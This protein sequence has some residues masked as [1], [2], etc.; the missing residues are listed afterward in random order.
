VVLVLAAPSVLSRWWASVSCAALLVLAVLQPLPTP[1]WPPSGWVLVAC[2]IGQGDALVLAAGDGSAVVVDTG[3]DPDTVRRC[4]ERL[5]VRSVAAVVLTHLHADHVDGLSGV[6]GTWPVGEVEVGPGRSPPEA[7]DEMLRLAADSDVPVRT[8]GAGE[9][10]TAGVLSWQVLAPTYSAPPAGPSTSEDTHD[11]TTINNTSLVLLVDVSG[12]RLLL[13][14][15]IEPEVQGALLASGVDLDVDV[16]K[17][18][19]HGSAR[20]DPRFIEAADPEVA[21]VSVGAGNDYG[22]PDLPLLSDLAADGAEVARTDAEGGDIAVV[23]RN[24]VIRLVTR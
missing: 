3:P 9:H 19:H 2:D 6:L 18:P 7:W 4:L 1:G 17:V 12:I 8:V 13:T 24:G 23:V 5:D 20:Q 11:G 14:G 22:H 15:D 21:V 10:A 16:L